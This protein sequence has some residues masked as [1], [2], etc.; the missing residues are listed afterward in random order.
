MN[1]IPIG[2]AQISRITVCIITYKRQRFLQRL[3]QELNRQQTGGLFCYQIG[4]T[5]NDAAESARGVVDEFRKVAQVPIRYCVEHRQNISMARNKAVEVAQGDY[6]AFIDD[7]EFP[8]ETW[9]LTL[10]KACAEFQADGVLGPVKPCFEQE[11]PEWVIK[12]KFHERATYPTGFV[13]DW[14]KGRTGNV[15]LKRSLFV[16]EAEPFRPE[17]LTGEDQDFFR[18]MIERGYKFVWCDEAVAYE[19]TPPMRS[20]PSFMLKKALLRGGISL[21]EPGQELPLVLK[22]LLAV[23]VYVPAL[24]FLLVA[25]KHLFMRYLVRT[26]DHLGRLLGFLNINPVKQKYLTE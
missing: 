10:F 25:G 16:G 11:P 2:G 12:G 17:F 8:T 6:L 19:F 9:L 20:K 24:P 18:R 15:L 5:D 14:R 22:S 21:L 1:A 3:L 26:F 4:V 7:D 23:A 13:I